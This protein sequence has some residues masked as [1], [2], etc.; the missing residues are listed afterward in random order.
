MGAVDV[1][2]ATNT[3]TTQADRPRAF[4]A[5]G[6]MAVTSMTAARRQGGITVVPGD[7]P[8]KL[9]TENGLALS[10]SVVT[11]APPERSVNPRM[12]F[13]HVTNGVRWH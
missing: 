4:F 5:G 10:K 6:L 8:T 12:E 2:T 13:F 3:D 7:V 11:E 9:F 1:A